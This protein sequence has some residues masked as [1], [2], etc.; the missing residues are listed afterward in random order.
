MSTTATTA[1]TTATRAPKGLQE[2]WM[3]DGIFEGEPTRFGPYDTSEKAD[4]TLPVLTDAGLQNAVVRV[5]YT[6]SSVSAFAKAHTPVTE[7]TPVSPKPEAAKPE[8]EAPAKPGPK[9]RAPRR[10]RQ[11]AKA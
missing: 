6:C 3:V 1:S 11:P 4:K 7:T 5:I 2:K 9:A 8:V 10:G